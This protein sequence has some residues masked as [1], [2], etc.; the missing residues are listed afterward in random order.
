MVKDNLSFSFRLGN[1]L[2]GNEFDE[3]I[4]IKDSVWSHPYQSHRKW[5]EDNLEPEDIHLIVKSE[6][7]AIAYLN[8][9]NLTVMGDSI[10]NAL[11]IGNVCVYPEYQ[12]KNLGFLLIKLAEYQISQLKKIGIL[13]CKDRVKAF[14]EKCGWSQFKGKVSFK[15]GKMLEHNIFVD[16]YNKILLSQPKLILSRDF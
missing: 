5:I 1:S 12:G 16:P 15:D 3:I 9:V 2:T 6:D 4:R 14:Y 8:M 7:N 11:G 10:Y 13:I